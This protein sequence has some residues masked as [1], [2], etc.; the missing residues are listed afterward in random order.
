[1]GEARRGRR[2]T[3]PYRESQRC[4]RQECKPFDVS[5]EWGWGS[6]HPFVIIRSPYGEHRHTYA[7]NGGDHRALRNLRAQVRR[8]LIAINA[9]LRVSVKPM[10]GN[11]MSKWYDTALAFS[12]DMAAAPQDEEILLLIPTGDPSFP[13]AHETGM[14]VEAGFNDDTAPARFE[15]SWR[16]TELPYSGND[17]IAWARFPVVHPELEEL[18]RAAVANKAAA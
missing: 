11:T 2:L 1:M 5:L 4:I 3:H 18:A 7:F 10:E 14:W 17:P 9:Q 12:T 13:V 8:V 16:F 15:G 6:R